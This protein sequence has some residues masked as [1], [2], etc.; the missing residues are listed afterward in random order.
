MRAAWITAARPVVHS[1]R[2]TIDPPA[3]RS[4]LRNEILLVLGVSVGVSAIYALVS[5][6]AKLTARGTLAQQTA[7][8]NVSRAP[9]RPWLDL[10]YQLVDIAVS[11]VP[12]LLAVHLLNR[13]PGDARATLGLDRSQPRFDAATGV[14][15]AALI[16]IPGLGLYMPRGSSGSTRR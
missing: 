9:E 7:A 16:G 14:G 10:T 11:L 12:V 3:R 13:D 6:T 5:L 15:L 8:L 2:V 4:V 1:E